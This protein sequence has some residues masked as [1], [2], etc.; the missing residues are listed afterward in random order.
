M[1]EEGARFALETF[2]VDFKHKLKL[3]LVPSSLFGC[4]AIF[5]LPLQTFIISFSVN[6]ILFPFLQA[7]PF[8]LLSFVFY[9][10]VFLLVF[11]SPDSSKCLQMN[12]V[13]CEISIVRQSWLVDPSSRS[14]TLCRIRN[15]K[16]QSEAC[17]GSS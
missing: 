17:K 4:G 13:S 12:P 14:L 9:F 5:N 7:E 6:F 3:S 15:E 2:S 11:Y 8:C 10:F 1:S 16:T